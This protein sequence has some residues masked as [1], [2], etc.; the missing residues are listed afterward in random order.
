MIYSATSRAKKKIGI[1]ASVNLAA[2]TYPAELARSMG[3]AAETVP[4]AQPVL[5]QLKSHYDVTML[6]A[7]GSAFQKLD[8]VVVIHPGTSPSRRSRLWTDM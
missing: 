1:L 6:A 8:A 7:D 5:E 4:K 3:L 2:S